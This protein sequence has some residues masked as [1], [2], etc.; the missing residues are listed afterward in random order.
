VNAGRNSVGKAKTPLFPSDAEGCKPSNEN[1][2]A[3]HKHRLC[4]KVRGDEDPGNAGWTVWMVS[5]AVDPEKH[6]CFLRAISGS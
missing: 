3:T 4:P 1:I 2:A 5:I 6:E